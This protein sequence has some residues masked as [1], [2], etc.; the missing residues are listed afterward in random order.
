MEN[1]GFLAGSAFRENALIV[2]QQR[3]WV[4]PKEDL[5]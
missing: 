5:R 1:E 2:R 4:R 3:I